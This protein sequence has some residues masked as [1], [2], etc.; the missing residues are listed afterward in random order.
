MDEGP[1]SRTG[2]SLHRPL[3]IYV[4]EGGRAD[5]REPRG[6]EKLRAYV[7]CAVAVPTLSEEQLLRILPRGTN[8]ERLKSSSL[9]MS[10][11]IATAFLRALLASDVEIAIVQIDPG[12]AQSVEVAAK[13]TAR[14][15]EAREAVHHRQV[16]QQQFTYTLFVARA[17]INVLAHHAKRR[18]A[19]PTFLDVVL[20]QANLGRVHERQFVDM[21]RHSAEQA[22]ITVSEVRWSDEQAHPLLLLPDI[23]AGVLYR[24]ATDPDALK[25]DSLKLLLQAGKS[26][27]IAVQDGYTI[28]GRRGGSQEGG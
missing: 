2:P 20:D 15:N 8:G 17:I 1:R 3:T 14:V 4:D 23:V 16:T 25:M 5:Y 19:I 7:P 28:G 21:I 22:E 12:S 6:G 18:K 27:G 24:G 10:D 13:A 26:G 9:E 11:A